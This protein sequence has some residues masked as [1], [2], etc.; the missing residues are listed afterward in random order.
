MSRGVR[1]LGDAQNRAGA[2]E[3]SS[4]EKR[5]PR[6]L[7]L[8]ETRVWNTAR[9]GAPCLYLV[10]RRGKNPETRATYQLEV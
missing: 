7:A 6:G 2:P 3:L 8:F 1:D 5:V 4:E 9:P 10:P